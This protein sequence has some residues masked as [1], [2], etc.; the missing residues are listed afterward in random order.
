MQKKLMELDHPNIIKMHNFNAEAQQFL[1]DQQPKKVAYLALDYLEASDL[2]STIGEQGLPENICR[3]VILQILE[4]VKYL[5][6]EGVIHRNIKAENIMVCKNEDDYVIKLIE[7]D[8]CI[9]KPVGSELI[10]D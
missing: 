5:H 10:R 9:Q 8:L 6:N 3:R 1:E 2:I 4:A 7:F